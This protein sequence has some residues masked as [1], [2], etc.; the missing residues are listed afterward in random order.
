MK[1]WILLVIL[2]RLIALIAVVAFSLGIIG[3]AVYAVVWHF[4]EVKL[5]FR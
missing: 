1:R 2:G 5:L 4:D 3:E